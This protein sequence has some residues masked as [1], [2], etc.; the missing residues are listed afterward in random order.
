MIL[1]FDLF[2]PESVYIIIIFLQEMAPNDGLDVRSEL[3]WVWTAE[4]CFQQLTIVLHLIC[5][6]KTYNKEQNS[7]GCV[8]WQ[9]MF[10][11]RVIRKAII[12]RNKRALWIKLVMMGGQM[13]QM[14]VLW[15]EKWWCSK[16]KISGRKNIGN[17][18][19]ELIKCICVYLYQ[20][21]VYSADIVQEDL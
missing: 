8:T 18:T 15:Y 2:H 19:F 13:P 20:Y 16:I 6:C 21:L 9:T 10:I 4:K 17:Q 7:L 14:M 5:K 1:Y 11:I 3:Q 12:I